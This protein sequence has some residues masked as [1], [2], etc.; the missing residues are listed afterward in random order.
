[1]GAEA[2]ADYR[3][4]IHD[5][6]TVHAMCEDY[7]AGLGLDRAHDDADRAAGRRVACPT[8]VLW[9]ARDD[10]PTSTATRW[11]SGAMGAGRAPGRSTPAT[12]WPRRPRSSWR[13]NCGGSC[14]AAEPEGYCC[15]PPRSSSSAHSSSPGRKQA[16][17]P[18]RTD[19]ARSSGTT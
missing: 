8:L 13:R 19:M 5:P 16:A 7:R 12:T 2:Y 15:G 3:R 4:A 14:C 10:L 11:P 17:I 18:R 9:A 6:A 1:M